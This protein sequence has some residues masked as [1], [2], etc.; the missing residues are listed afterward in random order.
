MLARHKR[1]PKNL[2]LNDIYPGW[3]GNEGIFDSLTTAPW[4]ASVDKEGLDIAYHGARSG[5]KFAAPVLYNFISAETGV[6]TNAGYSAVAKMLMAKYG[7]KWSHLW[8]LY[9]AEYNPLNSYNITE[10]ESRDIVKADTSND[11][12]TLFNQIRE[13]IDESQSTD[14][15]STRTPSI[16]ETLTLNT[17]EEKDSEVVRTPNL[18]ERVDEDSETVETPN[19][20]ERLTLNTEKTNTDSSIRTPAITEATTITKSETRTPNLTDRKVLDEDVSVEGTVDEETTYGRITETESQSTGSDTLSKWGFNTAA[21]DPVPA[22]TTASSR[23]NDTAETN[24][25]SDT[26]DRATT[27]TTERDATETLTKTGTEQTSGT[28]SHSVSTTGTESI[29]DSKLEGRTGTETTLK[30]GTD[31]EVVD[32][33]V[34]TATT[35]TDTTANDES[36]ARTGTETTVTSGTETE[37]IT[38]TVTKDAVNTTTYNTNIS[39][40]GSLNGTVDEDVERTKVGNLFKSPAELMSIDRDFWLTDYFEIVFAD[41]D[42]MLT[43]S[44]FSDSPVR[45]KY[46]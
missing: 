30:S 44:I 28:E 36:T 2:C 15:D 10:S 22:T 5:D 42:A 19:I 8:E 33:S 16:T 17:L 37:D 18:T 43:L 26:L 20:T 38:E 14:Y 29:A 40:H 23:D 21:A 12:E 34:I 13:V 11:T 24:S 25:G 32:K 45:V 27:E 3:L 4:Y 31:T 6:I 35:G 39:K 1:S 41:I 7:R 9:T 46:F